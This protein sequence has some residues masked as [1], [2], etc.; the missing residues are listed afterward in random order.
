MGCCGRKNKKVKNTSNDIQ[1]NSTKKINVNNEKEKKTIS[2]DKIQ[3]PTIVNQKQVLQTEPIVIKDEIEE[4]TKATSAPIVP[5]T[6]DDFKESV[7]KISSKDHRTPI[8]TYSQLQK[9]VAEEKKPVSILV[10]HADYCP[11]SK[12]T[13]PGL[14]RWAQANQDR[15]GLYEI[16]VEQDSNLA[17]YYHVRTIPT[18]MA[19]DEQN[20][21]APIWQRTSK[22]VLPLSSTEQLEPIEDK[23]EKIKD[24]YV[25]RSSKIQEEEEDSIESVNESQQEQESSEFINDSTLKSVASSEHSSYLWNQSSQSIDTHTSKVSI[26]EYRGRMI[27]QSTIAPDEQFRSKHSNSFHRKQQQIFFF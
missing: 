24:V 13:L 22:N 19:F 21:I 27:S 18:I 12:R 14:R 10:F 20:L 17:E 6:D 11:Y 9:S 1:S 5:N 4:I 16:D 26:P 23:F 15:I 25:V 2:I 3:S 7:E 8:K